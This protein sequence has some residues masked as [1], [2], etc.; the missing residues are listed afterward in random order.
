M[1]FKIFVD[2]SSDM[3]TAL[4]RKLD[5]DYFR[6]GLVVNGE[7]KYAEIARLLKIS[8]QKVYYWAQICL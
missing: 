4:R 1:A 6:M 5:I 2:S 8:R 7:M 3:P